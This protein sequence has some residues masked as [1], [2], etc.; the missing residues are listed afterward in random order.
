MGVWKWQPVSSAASVWRMFVLYI[1]AL[2]L[3]DSQGIETIP[4]KLYFKNLS[5]NVE[6]LCRSSKPIESCSVKIPGYS[7][8]FDVHEL[9]TG[10][11][12]YGNS[13]GQGDCGILF[14]KIKSINE[15]KFECNL[16]VGGEV[17]TGAIEVVQGIPPQP[18]E[19]AIDRN[20]I[21]EHGGFIPN[22]TLTMKCI[23][24]D[25]LPPANLSWYLEDT[26]MDSSL[27]G[28]IEE[29]T[30]TDKKGK[31]LTTLQQEL[32]YFITTEDTKKKV[33]CKAEHF[34]IGKGAYRATL[35]LNIRYPPQP[36][37]TIYI[38]EESQALIN[39]TIKANPKPTTSWKVNG[40]TI[41][42]GESMGPYQAYTPR[43]ME[44]GNFLIRL[45]I[46]E[47]TR[48]SEI[49]ELTASNALGAQTYV[50]KASKYSTDDNE[51]K[52]SGSGAVFWLI[53]IW[54]FFSSV[55]ITCL[56]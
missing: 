50:I 16:T 56:L 44:F 12:Y 43:D 3:V 25:A 24:Q 48:P 29:T 45:K 27:L 36:I 39:V 46:N 11:Q 31:I 51:T 33:V 34:A 1:A 13:L 52:P 54:T 22:Q 5:P 4:Q 38:G 7:K 21:I 6:L 15:G 9:P 18:T 20:A 37:P 53:S 19:I 49:F 14:E 10:I 30:K 35:P 42:E 8:P 47:K 28:P 26:P 55:I 17:F 2:A 40:V 23:S 41:D 32:R